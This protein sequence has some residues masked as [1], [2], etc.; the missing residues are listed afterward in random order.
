MWWF[1]PLLVLLVV[2]APFMMYQ[3]MQRPEAI[4]FYKSTDRSTEGL[5]IRNV[6]DLKMTLNLAPYQFNNLQQVL[7]GANEEYL[8]M[9]LR[10][11]S[12][13]T[14][15]KNHLIV[16]IHPFS[17]EV[18]QLESRVRAK[19]EAIV[20]YGRWGEIQKQLPQQGGFFAFGKDQAKIEI[21]WD[22]TWYHWRVTRRPNNTAVPDEEGSGVQ[23]PS[24]YRRFWESGL[25]FG[26]KPPLA[27]GTAHSVGES[28]SATKPTH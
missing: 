12:H 28:T 4:P 21:W 3:A 5:L 24:A 25:Q 26:A 16:T 20:Q 19:I 10:H 22:G 14:D 6:D 8:E 9:E 11:T 17:E 1:A 15:E 18:T 23:L 2:L 7:R 27:T 13:M